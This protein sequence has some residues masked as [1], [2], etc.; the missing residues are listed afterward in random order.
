[1]K[2][3]FLKS[4]IRQVRIAKAA[5]EEEG[6]DWD[7]EVGQTKKIEYFQSTLDI[8]NAAVEKR[9]QDRS[10]KVA[11]R[12]AAQSAR[13]EKIVEEDI[14][15]EWFYSPGDLVT[16][17]PLS[18]ARQSNYGRPVAGTIAVIIN[19]VDMCH[20]GVKSTGET[21]TVM[22]DGRIENWN[23]RWVKHFD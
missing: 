13:S 17:K 10:E 6:A 2:R 14:S 12:R 23:A 18:K 5:A 8:K 11:L 3:K 16:V 1:M 4:V 22:V 7:S 9:R 15:T 20:K 19:T 21:I